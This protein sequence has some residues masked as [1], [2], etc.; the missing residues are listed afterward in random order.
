MDRTEASD[1]FNAGSIPVGCI[2]A[3]FRELFITRSEEK[4]VSRLIEER[5]RNDEKK[6]DIQDMKDF[7]VKDLPKANAIFRHTAFEDKLPDMPRDGKIIVSVGAHANFSDRLTE[8]VDW[9]CATY[10]AAVLCDHTSGYRGKYEVHYQLVCGQKQ[11]KSPL[12]K[13]NLCIH[14]GE[15]SGNSFAIK[16][17]HTWRVSPDGKL[18]DTFGNLRR[19][20]MMPHQCRGMN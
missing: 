2:F 16:A 11:W 6:P 1:A 7:S 19:V 20:F 14:I 9:F 5:K 12:A 13:A 15:V 4:K 18:R 8:A 10:D 17:A 3:I